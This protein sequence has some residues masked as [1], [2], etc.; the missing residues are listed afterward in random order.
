M[1]GGKRSFRNERKN[2]PKP[3]KKRAYRRPPGGHPPQ[4][5]LRT[6]KKKKGMGKSRGPGKKNEWGAG[7]TPLP[8]GKRDPTREV[9]GVEK[10]RSE[11]FF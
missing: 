5:D 8:Q 2:L 7:L 6:E 1:K 9:R 11:I 3:K 10:K 4:E